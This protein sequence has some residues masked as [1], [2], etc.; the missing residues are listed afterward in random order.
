MTRLHGGPD[1]LGPV[2]H[3]FSTN[4]NACGPC[5]AVWAAVHAADASRYPDPAYRQ[6]R[7]HLAAHHGVDAW[8]VVVAA[9][10]SEA[11]A[12]LTALCVRQGG[13]RVAVPA[14]AYGD[15][16]A[17]AHAWGLEVVADVQGGV[18]APVAMRWCCDPSSPMGVAEAPPP[19]GSATVVV[20]DRAYAPLR[21]GGAPCPWDAEALDR[22]WQ[23]W[24]PNKALG[25]TGVRGAYLIAP[26][27]ADADVALLVDL[28]PSWP[29]GAHAVAMLAGWPQPATQAWLADARQTLQGWKQ[30]QIALLADLGWVCHASETPYFCAQ[31]PQ[32]LSVL[33]LRQRGIKLRDATSMG[34]PG[35]WRLGVRSPAEQDVLRQSLE[36]AG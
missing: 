35:V 29:L 10:G 22:V 5:P 9:S 30:R 4:S 11:I 7:E 24:S 21:L 23:L 6:L 28:A 18:P 15:Y 19:P 33:A 36:A 31:P 27:G 20:L 26:A 17:A 14:L 13:R 3:D 16:A 2:P 1:G 34:L 8:R 12:R 25:L 32:P